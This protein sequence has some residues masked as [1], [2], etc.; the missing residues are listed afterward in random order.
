MIKH[1]KWTNE[2]HDYLVKLKEQGYTYQQIA[3]ELT[4][5]F[6]QKFTFDGVRNRYRYKAEQ[7]GTPNYKETT[8]IL[9]D[10]SHKS[11]K[12]LKMSVEQSKDVN[13]LLKAHGFDT[14]QWEL[15][16]AK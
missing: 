13:Y 5:T 15:V 3:D 11:D 9:A 6:N 16:N 2:E 14:E 10:G 12:L 4:T 8:E 1:D 7:T